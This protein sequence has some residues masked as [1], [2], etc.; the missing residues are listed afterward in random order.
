VIRDKNPRITG[1]I[2]LRQYPGKTIQKVLAILIVPEYFS[3]L[4]PPDHEMM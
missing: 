3:A 2:R 4:D 1:G